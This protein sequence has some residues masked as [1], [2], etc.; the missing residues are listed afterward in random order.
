MWQWPINCLYG[1]NM[2]GYHI[3]KWIP[4]TIFAQKWVGWMHRQ[5]PM[6]FLSLS[7][8]NLF[9]HVLGSMDTCPDG[10]VRACR[11][12]LLLFEN[13]S[14]TTKIITA[15]FS[16]C[17][18]LEESED[19]EAPTETCASWTVCVFAELIVPNGW[20]TKQMSR[21]DISFFCDS[22]NTFHWKKEQS[23]PTMLERGVV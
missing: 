15:W 14:F 9:T 12:V 20:G 22:H 4:S 19:R 1:K 2:K 16:L 8:I 3:P 5:I 13:V 17:C 6:I 11:H 18:F 21:I 7:W 23:I 10:G